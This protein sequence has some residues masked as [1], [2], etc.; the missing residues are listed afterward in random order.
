M[1]SD[2]GATG[3]VIAFLGD[4]ETETH[5]AHG[6]EFTLVVPDAAD[7][8]VGSDDLFDSL[9]DASNTLRVGERD[10]QVFMVA[11]PTGTVDWGVRGL[12]TGP[13]DL[14][15]RDNERLDDPDNVWLHEYVHTRQGY[16]AGSDLRWFTE[17]TATYYAALL[18]LEQERI[19]FDSF[20]NRLNLGNQSRLGSSVLAEPPTWQR[21]ADYNVGALVSGE[22]DRQLRL[23]TGGEQSFEE[24]FRKMN[25]HE[26]LVTA[27]EFQQFLEATAGSSVAD[28]GETY[29][30]TTQRPTMCDQQ[31]HDEAFGPTPARITYSLSP[32]DPL[33]VSGEYRD[34]TIGPNPVLVPGEKLTVEISAENFGGSTGE[35]DVALQVDGEVRE[36][37]TGSLDPGES[38]PL[39]FAE[40]FEETGEFTLSVGSVDVPVSVRE[41]A[42]P[43]VHSLFV[44]ETDITVGE[45]VT[46]DATV[47]NHA[48]YPG[49]ID[50]PLLKNDEEIDRQLVRL[51]AESGTTLSFEVTLEEEG[52]YVLGLGDTT[53]ET[54][55]VTVE[56]PEADPL[57]GDDTDDDVPNGETEADDDG[58]GLG[59]G[60]AL[61]GLFVLFLATVTRT[62]SVR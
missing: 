42:T 38:T 7:L 60:I 17:G 15:T 24:V 2:V 6:Q 4:H 59:V 55:I 46:L 49:R 11:A 14:W 9:S 34:R 28:L 40:P 8:A 52:T 62:F 47:E 22:L 39:S 16:T 61:A 26:G 57:P 36:R 32:T 41:P 19:S 13:A 44:S 18:S 53:A 5:D 45:T 30:Q 31:A 12:Q 58:A 3:D 56:K 21:G 37:K 25:T 50:V 10:E 23:A 20:R 51:D 27:R 33:S 35:Y 43:E 29:T 54:V 1:Q 48:A